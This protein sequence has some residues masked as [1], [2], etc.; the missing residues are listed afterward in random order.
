MEIID[1]KDKKHEDIIY[2]IFISG[3]M[4]LLLKKK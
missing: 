3:D 2:D 4:D 1:D